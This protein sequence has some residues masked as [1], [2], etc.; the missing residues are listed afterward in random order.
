MTDSE[1][2][3]RDETGHRG[4]A[5]AESGFLLPP[6]VLAELKRYRA[7]E[8]RLQV[9]R[10]Q[11]QEFKELA[12]QVASGNAAPLSTPLS[13]GS[14]AAELDAALAALKQEIE[15]IYQIDAELNEQVRA[16]RGS[17]RSTPL[18]MPSQVQWLLIREN[19]KIALWV[20]GG[21]VLFLLLFMVLHAFA[22]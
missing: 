14:P 12:K 18:S 17:T 16:S 11:S 13:D 9:S 3:R 10:R 19:M 7:L 21:I 8:R 4:Q 22:H 6:E 20:G 2:G 1:T 15:T 5:G